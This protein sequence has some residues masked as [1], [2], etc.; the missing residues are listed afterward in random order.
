[1]ETDTPYVWT[2]ESFQPTLTIALKTAE[3]RKAHFRSLLSAAFT[4]LQAVAE[5]Y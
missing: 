4:F 1:M 2:V 5:E 3:S